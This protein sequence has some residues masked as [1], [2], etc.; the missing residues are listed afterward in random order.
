MRKKGRWLISLALTGCLLFTACAEEEV[1]Q[2]PE[3]VVSDEGYID[4]LT[5]K[6]DY[7]G[8]I[9]AKD[10]MET[11]LEG[12]NVRGTLYDLDHEVRDQLD[13]IIDEIAASDKAFEAGSNEQMIHD[14][15]HLAYDFY[16][17]GSDMDE[18]DTA[19]VD[20][21][22]EKVNSVSSIDELLD[23]WSELIGSYG[24]FPVIVISTT[25]NI[26]DIDEYILTVNISLPAD[27]EALNRSDANAVK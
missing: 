8:Y 25:E 20:G 12:R 11:D 10:L 1:Q 18:Y 27:L 26:Y 9:N 21:I 22:V 23:T 2:A 17:D 4:S 3:K 14:L 6:N 15:Y 5:P 16:E 7:Y 24:I 13:D 19:L